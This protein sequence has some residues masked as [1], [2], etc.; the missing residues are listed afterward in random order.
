MTTIKLDNGKYEITTDDGRLTTLRYGEEWR[1]DTGDGLIYSLVCEIESL[2]DKI[3][4]AKL[5]V[6]KA[7]IASCTCTTKS[8]ALEFHEEW[9]KYRW[10]GGIRKVLGRED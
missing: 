7:S 10:L 6:F 5:L 4:E 2:Q 9:C 1:D 3:N 8:P